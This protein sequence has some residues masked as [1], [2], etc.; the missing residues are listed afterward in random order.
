MDPLVPLQTVGRRAVTGLNVFAK[1]M[2]KRPRGVVG[3]ERAPTFQD[4]PIR[5]ERSINLWRGD[6][7]VEDFVP[8]YVDAIGHRFSDRTW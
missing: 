7:V 3:V 1:M 4:K 6:R 8:N 5:Y 2:I